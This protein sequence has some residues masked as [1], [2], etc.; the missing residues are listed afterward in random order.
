MASRDGRVS[1]R[2]LMRIYG[3]GALALAAAVDRAA[4]PEEIRRTTK[5][6]VHV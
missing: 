2:E 1:R 4:A 3:A 6:A 5:G